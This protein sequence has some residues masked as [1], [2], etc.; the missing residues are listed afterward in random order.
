MKNKIYL[1][2]LI[3]ALSFASCEKQ[4]EVNPKNSI[5]SST[6]LTSVASSEALLISAYD[7]VQTFTYWGRDMALMGDVLADNISVN[8]SQASNRYVGQGNNSRNS[9]Y[10]FW[11]TAYG[12]INDCNTLIEYLGTQTGNEAKK[13][14]L[15]GEALALRAMVFFDLARVYGYEPNKIPTT[16]TGAGFNKSAILRTK[17]TAAAE[18]AVIKNRSTVVETYTQIEKDLK[19]AIAIIPADGV[20]TR[21]RMNKGAAYAL[22]GKVYLYWE[23]WSDAVTQFDLAMANTSAKLAT[24]GSYTAAFKTRP[25]TESFF[26]LAFDQVTELS[27][28]TGQNE[29]L[30]S[31]TAPSGATTTYGG[32]LPSVEL[33][34]LFDDGDDR[35][36]MFYT[37]TTTTSTV[38]LPF[39]RKYTQVGGAYTDN[40]VIIRYADVLLMKAEALAE[41]GQ[42]AA[43]AALVVQLRTNRNATTAGVPTTDAIKSYIQTERRRELFYEGHRWFDLKRKGNG[44]SKPA[45]GGVG[46]IS[47]NDYRILAPIPSGSITF[48]PALP[49]NPG[50]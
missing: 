35:K 42:Y 48:N 2:S 39:V 15:K 13:N 11:N 24:A 27:G 12:I 9:H 7:R 16:G 41:Q 50:Y 5:A 32:Q 46:S 40:V 19:D 1:T 22:L 20:T 43:A 10:N 45:A 28:V 6:A 33:R 8:A 34:S 37:S 38:A 14:Q 36:A 44:I 31:Y 47:P 18:D 29:S 30:Y 3:V 26:E 21:L 17:A 49:Q 4:L 23:K 25:N